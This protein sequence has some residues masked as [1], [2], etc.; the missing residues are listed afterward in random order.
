MFN[1]DKKKLT[2]CYF[3]TYTSEYSRNSILI[4]GL[5]KNEVNVVEC[6]TIRAGFLK[7]IDLTIKHWR[8][9]NKYDIMIVGFQGIQ[10]VI[11][12]RVLT[13]KTIIFDAFASIYDSMVMDRKSV[14]VNS[15]VAKYYWWLDK[16]SMTLADIVLFDT[17]E[18]IDYASKEFG[19]KKEKLRRIFAGSD[20]DI[21]YPTK[22]ESDSKS[23]KVFFYGSFLPLHGIDCILRAAKF[24]EKEKDIFF[25]ITG[26]GPEKEKIMKLFDELKSGNLSFTGGLNKELLREKMAEADLCLGIFGDT[27]KTKRVIPNKVYDYVAMRKPVVTAD[28]SAIR[29]LFEDGELMLVKVSDHIS[30]ANA[31]MTIKNNRE[32]AESLAQKGYQKFLKFATPSI[33]GKRLLGI[34]KK[35]EYF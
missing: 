22:K 35:N 7:Y 9:R 4:S 5:K 3:G 19:I 15:F 6:K 25:E 11:L 2:V 8:I 30:L 23:F 1:N 17:N 14:K 29:E 20:V 16:I 31:I 34:I 10:A 12:A 33:L 24:L 13:R 21:F 18:N 26:W 28:T 27:N 32:M